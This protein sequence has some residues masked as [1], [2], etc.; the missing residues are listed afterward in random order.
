MKRSPAD[1][2]AASGIWAGPGS[3]GRRACHKS[4]T[5]EAYRAGAA[6]P[7]THFPLELGRAK[8]FRGHFSLRRTRA[9]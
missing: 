6:F 1:G 7:R 5:C 3:V 2:M 4:A 8:K 9:S